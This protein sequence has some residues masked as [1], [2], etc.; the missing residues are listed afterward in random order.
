MPS[1]LD[2]KYGRLSPHFHFLFQLKRQSVNQHLNITKIL[3]INPIA[4][5]IGQ[6]IL[7]IAKILRSKIGNASPTLPISAEKSNEETKLIGI[8][9]CSKG[10][11]ENRLSNDTKFCLDLEIF[12]FICSMQASFMNDSDDAN[13]GCNKIR[14]KIQITS[15]LSK[16]L[17]CI[18]RVGF[19]NF[20]CPIFAQM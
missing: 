19:V 9:I 16:K 17:R 5:R 1:N 8:F 12:T 20:A 4:Y 2:S 14:R 15:V 11:E 6:I 10:L 18:G 7:P 3:V 13:F